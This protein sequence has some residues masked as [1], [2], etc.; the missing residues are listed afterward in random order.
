MEL[1]VRYPV[2]INLLPKKYLLK[3]APNWVRLFFLV[4]LIGFTTFFVYTYL[5]VWIEIMSLENE[6]TILSNEVTQLKAREQRLQKVQEEVNQIEKRIEIL[7]SLII[8]E[9]DWLKILDLIGSSMPA[10]LYFEEASFDSGQITCRGKSRSIFSLARFIEMISRYP[11]TFTSA[12][13]H[14]LQLMPD[15]QSYQFN[16][17]LGLKTP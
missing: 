3:K 12:D 2:R 16:L 6:N 9:P 14:S 17:S 5:V 4:L 7:R 1:R 11:D 15:G 13:F 10:D 8:S